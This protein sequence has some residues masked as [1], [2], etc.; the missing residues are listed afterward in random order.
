[1]LVVFCVFSHA[2]NDDHG[3]RRGNTV[4]ALA[5]WQHLVASCEATV[6]LHPAML[7]ALYRPGSM[8]IEISVKL[9]TFVYIV[10][11]SASRKK[12]ISP[13]FL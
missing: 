5:R 8:I 3:G 11:N 4:W 6:V 12:I 2:N 13:S 9:V 7:I 10:D 1:M